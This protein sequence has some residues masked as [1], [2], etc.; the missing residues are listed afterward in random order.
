MQVELIHANG[1]K[2]IVEVI[3]HY[4][5]QLCVLWGNLAG[6]YYLDLKTNQ[7]VR[8]RLWKAKDIEEAKRIWKLLAKPQKEN[9][10]KSLKEWQW[11]KAK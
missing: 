7:L 11:K 1:D 6:H 9:V 8:A 3:G 10:D 2:K 4:R 5:Y